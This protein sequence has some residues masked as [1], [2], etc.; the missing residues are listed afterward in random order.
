LRR[1]KDKGQ[2]LGKLYWRFPFLM[3]AHHLSQPLSNSQ[4]SSHLPWD[5]FI[6]S[7][8][9][10]EG[11]LLKT[12]GKINTSAGFIIYAPINFFKDLSYF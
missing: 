8:V 3:K 10:S 7:R 11:A 9:V 6:S 1:S 12:F 5:S 2:I 4:E